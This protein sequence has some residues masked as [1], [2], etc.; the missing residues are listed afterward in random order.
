MSNLC[1]TGQPL[2]INLTNG[3]YRAVFAFQGGLQ[4]GSNVLGTCVG[5]DGT[6]WK[7]CEPWKGFPDLK[8]GIVADGPAIATTKNGLWLWFTARSAEGVEK[9]RVAYR[10]GA[11]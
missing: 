10:N 1:E 8:T 11:S 5:S 3:S 7:Y 4:S 6:A 2:D 9:I